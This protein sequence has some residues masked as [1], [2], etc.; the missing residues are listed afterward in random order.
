PREVVSRYLEIPPAPQL[1]DPPVPR[2]TASRDS[3][4]QAADLAPGASVAEC[5]LRRPKGVPRTMRHQLPLALLLATSTFA[6]VDNAA[7]GTDDADQ[8]TSALEQENGG[9]TLDDELPM[10]GDEAAFQA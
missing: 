8:V 10:F 9:L 6:C 7:S 5:L 4:R 2:E 1:A 3:S